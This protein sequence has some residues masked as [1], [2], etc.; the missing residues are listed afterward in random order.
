MRCHWTFEVDWLLSLAAFF[1]AQSLWFVRHVE[2]R[3]VVGGT[4]ALFGGLVVAVSQSWVV[5]LCLHP[6][7]ACHRTAHWLWLWSGGLVGLGFYLVLAGRVPSAA[8]FAALDP[9]EASEKKPAGA[10]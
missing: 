5:G 2:A 10:A 9:W 3:R 1:V 8:S 7:M 4:L 6:E